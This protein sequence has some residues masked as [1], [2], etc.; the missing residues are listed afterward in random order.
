MSWA[1]KMNTSLDPDTRH[2]ERD[3]AVQRRQVVTIV[4]LL[5]LWTAVVVVTAALGAYGFFSPKLVVVLM[6]RWYWAQLL[7]PA[8]GA[9]L[10]SFSYLVLGYFFRPAPLDGIMKGLGIAILLTYAHLFFLFILTPLHIPSLPVKSIPAIKD[11][12]PFYALYVFLY[13]IFLG[14]GLTRWYRHWLILLLFPQVVVLPNVLIATYSVVYN[15]LTDA[16]FVWSKASPLILRALEHLWILSG[17]GIFGADECLR[18]AWITLA[19]TMSG[20]ASALLWR[21]RGR[22]RGDKPSRY[23]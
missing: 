9:V 11:N 12:L 15:N 8:I 7:L 5:L 18:D 6:G 21:G 3:L 4:E 19:F 23:D 20:A 22:E 17:P 1:A 2:M 10:S 16:A 14:Y 13:A